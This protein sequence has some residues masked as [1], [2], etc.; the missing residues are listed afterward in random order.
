LLAATILALW[1]NSLITLIQSW[2]LFIITWS[3]FYGLVSTDAGKW[4]TILFRSC[5]LSISLI[6]LWL[7]NASNGGSI[8]SVSDIQNWTSESAYWALMAS[9]VFL[10]LILLHWWR[11]LESSLPTVVDS[12]IHL[13][14]T[15]CGGWLFIQV[16]AGMGHDST[17]RL[18]I[19]VLSLIGLLT[20]ATLAWVN[21]KHPRSLPPYLTLSFVNMVALTTIWLDLEAAA[22]ELNIS[23][24][25]L[26]GLFLFSSWSERSS[27]WERI[28]SFIFVIALAGLPLTI[29]FHGRSSLFQTWLDGGQL[30]LA[31]VVSLIL[32]AILGAAFL[33]V[34]RRDISITGADLQNVGHLEYSALLLLL[35]LGLIGFNGLEQFP[36]SLVPLLFILIPAL[37]GYLL[38]RYSVQADE[39]QQTVGRALDFDLH[40]RQIYEYLSVILSNIESITR[41]GAAILEG[42]GGML[43][44]LIIV[45]ILWM[46][47]IS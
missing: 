24:L 8:G 44:L 47:R 5:A 22:A 42:E 3:L 36:K 11:P 1:S 9:S 25:A 12:L 16:G 46:A 40:R 34:L 2:A 41:E 6:F 15:I 17:P 20:G 38:S 30:L 32:V 39:L 33:I 35:A 37:G 14:P 4:R 13:L 29:G 7:A 21:V 10:G 23:L 27:R 43:W 31:L 28:I 45:I 19:T 18:I 26:G